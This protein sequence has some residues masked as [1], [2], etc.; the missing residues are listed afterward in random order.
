MMQVNI[1]D[2]WRK[3][4]KSGQKQLETTYRALIACVCSAFNTKVVLLRGDCGT[5]TF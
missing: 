1:V 4:E 5:V 2:V 3:K